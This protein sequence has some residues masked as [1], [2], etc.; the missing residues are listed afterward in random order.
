MMTLLGSTVR[1]AFQGH[2][3]GNSNGAF[4]SFFKIK[5]FA[6]MGWQRARHDRA[7]EPKTIQK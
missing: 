3:F 1:E 5:Q 6:T 2:M 7:T 4:F